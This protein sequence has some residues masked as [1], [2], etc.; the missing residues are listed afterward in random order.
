MTIQG[1]SISTSSQVLSSWR[2]NLNKI[3][4][5]SPFTQID[6]PNKSI[7]DRIF[8]SLEASANSHADQPVVTEAFGDRRSITHND[9]RTKSLS[10][11]AF[12]QS[13]SFSDGDKATMI[14]PNCI[15]LP[16]FA[17]GVWTAGGAIVGSSIAYKTYE[18]RYQ[19]VDSQSVVVFT[20]EDLLDSIL[21]AVKECPAVKTIIC[22]RRSAQFIMP[23]GVVD[24]H[25][26]TNFEHTE[27]RRSVSLD[28]PA[29]VFYSS[30]TTGVPKGVVHTIRS[31]H[32]GIEQLRRHWE[33]EIF[34]KLTME[35]VDWR[36]ENQLITIPCY[37]LMGFTLLSW[38]LMAGSPIVLLQS[39]RE[40]VLANALSLFKPRFIVGHPAMAKFLTTDK[41]GCTADLTSVQLFVSSGSPIRSELAA[42]FVE[43]HPSVM[44][45]VQIYGMTEL[46]FC[47]LPLLG[48]DKVNISSGVLGAMY[49]Q[50]I[51]DVETGVACLQG[52][53]GEICLRGAPMTIGYLNKPK[54][55]AHLFDEEG[56]LH[57]GDIGYI[58]SNGELH[59]V[60]RLKELIKMNYNNVILQI[61]PSEIE[62]V[63]ISHPKII[64]A[65]IVGIEDNESEYLIRAFVV[66]TDQSLS[67][68]DVED[69]VTNH[70]ADYKRLT[71]GVRFIDA[72]PRS[73]S[74]KM[75]RLKLKSLNEAA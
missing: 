51:V 59:L 60:E 8:D 53:R 38:F 27:R 35:D 69:F 6:L 64:D 49:E 66:R 10:L 54:S 62:Q 1:Y 61:C 50:K 5:S 55:T 31:F 40:G 33:I 46:L 47:H 24:F 7:V 36:T 21:E 12:L 52:E 37:H 15:E 25:D 2:N 16:I 3:P 43:K 26:A 28:S 45:L 34:P 18:T 56:W 68:G 42:Q 63:L 73:E 17:L 30:G 65:A 71:G 9:L 14:V 57:T 58:D 67:E 4:L 39:F 48:K 11:A 23:E 70:L 19:L 29:L 13:R 20:T 32:A 72:I 74:G 41:S 22:I 75:Q 44:H